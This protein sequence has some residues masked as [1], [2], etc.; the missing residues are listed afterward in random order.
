[1][2]EGSLLAYNMNKLWCG[3]LNLARRGWKPDYFAMIHADIAPQDWWLDTLIEILEF[4]DL[5]VLGVAVP[6]KSPT[7]GLTSLALA[8]PD[9]STWRPLCRLTLDEVYSL[10]DPFTSADLGHPL[11]INTGLWVCRFDPTWA[12]KVHFEINDRI[13]EMPDGEYDAETEPEDWFITRLF[14]E[15]GLKIGATKEIK[16][17]HRGPAEFPNNQTWGEPFDSA[18]VDKSQLRTVER[19]GF[20]FPADVDGWL[21][22]EEGRALFDLARDKRVLEI[23]SYCGRSTI[24]LAQSARSVVAV[25]PHDGRGTPR[26]K[27]TLEIFGRN[28]LR[29]GFNGQIT[30]VVGT[31]SD[32]PDG[33][34]DLAFIDG[35]HDYHAVRDDIVGSLERLAPGGLLAFHDYKRDPGVTKAVNELGAAGAELVSIVGTLAVVRP[36]AAIPTEV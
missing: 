36:P 19:A 3:A 12:K 17:Q 24:C 16:L 10:P 15:L 35:S 7:E 28:M 32:A 5:D 9:G 13:V 2:R 8:R 23:G 25:D 18:Y 14:H 27:D 31:I 30:P 1:Y 21:S 26:A 6:I 4:S 11:L 33:P 22:F 20:R 34:F 29:Y